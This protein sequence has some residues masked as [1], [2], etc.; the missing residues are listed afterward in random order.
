VIGRERERSNREDAKIAK[1]LNREIDGA[2]VG[3]VDLSTEMIAMSWRPWRLGGSFLPP[4][5]RF[6]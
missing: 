6:M 3:A 2:D 5:H 4:C 1:H